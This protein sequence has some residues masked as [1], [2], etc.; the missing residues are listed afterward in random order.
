MRYVLLQPLS[1]EQ[2]PIIFPAPAPA[3][4][5]PAPDPVLVDDA[6]ISAEAA[7]LLLAA[8]VIA[9]YEPEQPGGKAEII[10]DPALEQQSELASQP[11]QP[12]TSTRKRST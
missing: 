3:E 6:L 1:P 4:G 9:P 2:G 10:S 7:P 5:E 8:G 12:T 11:E